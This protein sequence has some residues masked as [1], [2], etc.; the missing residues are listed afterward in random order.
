MAPST[1]VVVTDGVLDSKD[2][3]C[4]VYLFNR[5]IQY[6]RDVSVDGVK[7]EKE[8]DT[9]IDGSCRIYMMLLPEYDITVNI[10]RLRIPRSKDLSKSSDNQVSPVR[11]LDDAEQEYHR[12]SDTYVIKFVEGQNEETSFK[13]T[14][15]INS[16][17]FFVDMRK[18]KSKL[19]T[20]Y[21]KLLKNKV[22]EKLKE[23]WSANT[24]LHI[25]IIKSKSKY[26]KKHPYH[27]LKSILDEHPHKEYLTSLHDMKPNRWPFATMKDILKLHK[28]DPAKI[29]KRR[30]G[31][32][33]LHIAILMGAPYEIIVAIYKLYEQGIKEVEFEDGYT[34]LHLAI[35]ASQ[36]TEV[37]QFILENWP[38]NVRVEDKYGEYPI[39]LTRNDETLFTLVNYFVKKYN[40]TLNNDKSDK[41][42]EELNTI[43]DEKLKLDVNLTN[44]NAEFEH[45]N[46]KLQKYIEK[47]R[48]KRATEDRERQEKRQIKIDALKQSIYKMQNEIQV[49]TNKIN[50]LSAKILDLKGTLEKQIESEDK[51][52]KKLGKLIGCHKENKKGEL[53]LLTAVALG[54]S[55]KAVEL[56]YKVYKK[57]LYDTDRWG[58]NVIHYATEKLEANEMLDNLLTK[59]PIKQKGN[60]EK[61][62]S[63]YRNNSLLSNAR[64]KLGYRPL[65]IARLHANQDAALSLVAGQRREYIKKQQRLVKVCE[66][67]QLDLKTQ[68]QLL[69]DETKSASENSDI[70]KSIG[71]WKRRK[72]RYEQEIKYFQNSVDNPCISSSL[73]V[74]TSCKCNNKIPCIVHKKPSRMFCIC[75]KHNFLTQANLPVRLKNED[76]SIKINQYS[77]KSCQPKTK[78]TTSKKK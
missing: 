67:K 58:Y 65:D 54:S 7:E 56:L 20:K 3:Y 33:P 14:T 11:N 12:T 27:D 23:D 70:Q 2:N 9:D 15:H 41:I 35:Y 49:T 45:S 8:F 66:R 77:C 29:K 34:P 19:I 31:K 26:I 76:G 50:V 53:P 74:R 21:E 28:K 44:F 1:Q 10:F 4:F 71:V 30:F 17:I 75:T 40:I 51:D 42:R 37:V 43:T 73:S 57:G 78:S 64:N 13:P 61:I 16:A 32:L 55:E 22:I 63:G 59:Y 60:G 72:K 38:K 48:N 39:H 68:L 18:F 47:Q 6:V 46:T 5:K 36:T 52:F 25:C 69:P 62:R 24:Q